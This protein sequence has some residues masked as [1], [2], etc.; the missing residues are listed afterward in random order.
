MFGLG[1]TISVGQ[2]FKLLGVP[3]PPNGS[4][5]LPSVWLLLSEL[6]QLQPWTAAIGLGSLAA[7]LA[8]RRVASLLP[9]ALIVVAAATA[10]TWGCSTW[11]RKGSVRWVRSP[12][13][14]HRS[15]C[16]SSRRTT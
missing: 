12:V 16:P 10:V 6:G 13:A 11:T 14:C 5:F 2:A 3:A 15:R 9:A 1:Q 7:L 8:L 4:D